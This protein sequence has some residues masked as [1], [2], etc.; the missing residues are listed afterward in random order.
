MRPETG[1]K[2]YDYLKLNAWT[3]KDHFPKPF[4]DQI[5]KGLQKRGG[6]VFLMVIWVTTK[7]PL[8]QKIKIKPLLLILMEI[9][10]PRGYPSGCVLH[11]LFFRDV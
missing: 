7:S 10:C 1:W 5:W 4:M 11:R 9:S 6:I 2:V 3:E 8:H